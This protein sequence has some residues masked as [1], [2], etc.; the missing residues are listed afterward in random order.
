MRT[1]WSGLLFLCVAATAAAQEKAQPWRKA[2][3]AP[4]GRWS[5]SLEFDSV[6]TRDVDEKSL[7]GT[8]AD[9]NPPPPP[10]PL[11]PTTESEDVAL[12]STFYYLRGAYSFYAPPHSPFAVE[13]YVVLGLS[14]V[15]LD[16]DVNRAGDPTTD[17]TVDGDA[18]FTYGLGVRARLYK[19]QAFTLLA[20]AGVRWSSHDSDIEK[21]PNLELDLGAGETASQDFTTK[22]F[23]WNLSLYASYRIEAGQTI[24]APF[25]GLR[26][27][28]IDVDV[29]GKQTVSDPTP[30]KTID[31]DYSAEGDSVFGIFLGTEATFSPNF[32]AWFELRMVN[33]TAFTL[34]AGWRF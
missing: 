29:D 10:A 18:A 20:D 31:I 13:G 3:V 25:A 33:E 14:D 7:S 15:E 8:E 1:A 21:S 22:T 17:F 5:V 26:L 16:G 6:S 32:S 9:L 4:Q 2:D 30:D 28:A 27:S 23:H 12:T 11:D 34:G 24:I 19:T